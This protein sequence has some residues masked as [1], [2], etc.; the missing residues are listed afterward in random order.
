VTE[1]DPIKSL[2]EELAALADIERIIRGREYACEVQISQAESEL[3]AVRKLRGY[4]KIQVD[5]ARSK[6][7]KLEQER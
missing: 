5:V 2:R 6:L 7:T 1:F 3:N 4:V